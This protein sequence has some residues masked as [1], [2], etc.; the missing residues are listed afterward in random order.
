MGG[1]P[2]RQ[3]LSWSQ[4]CAKIMLETKDGSQKF[5]SWLMQQENYGGPFFDS[6]MYKK[7][8]SI[9]CKVKD[10]NKDHFIVVTG[11]EGVGKSTCAI[12]IACL[13]SP[14]FT[15]QNVCYTMSDYLRIIEEG[16][17]GD[18][19]LLDEGNLFLFSREAMTKENRN[20]IKLFALMRQK[21]IITVICVPQYKTIDPYVK[22]HRIDT[23]VY[24]CSTGSYFCYANKKALTIINTC[25]KK[26]LDLGKIRVPNGT[27]WPGHWNKGV[28]TMNDINWNEYESVKG[29]QFGEFLQELKGQA[30][31]RDGLSEWVKLADARKIVPLAHETYIK[32]IKEE[33]IPGKRIGKLYYV[34]RE[35]LMQEKP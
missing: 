28:P 35:W 16:K 26:G 10:K 8:Y 15:L 17:R 29:S 3:T 23:L 7:L 31:E 21:G 2:L 4:V 12:Q 33:T 14:R 18:V 1:K 27:F 24:C 5:K 32:Y 11:K 25:I 19:A 6:Y 13:L 34:K 22:E 9:Y 30:S 20:M